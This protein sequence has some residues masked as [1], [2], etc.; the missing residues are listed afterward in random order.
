MHL[1][2]AS[3]ASLAVATGGGTFLYAADWPA[4]CS[5]A[6]ACGAMLARRMPRMLHVC[7]LLHWSCRCL[8]LRCASDK[9]SR[10][11]EEHMWPITEGHCALPGSHNVMHVRRMHRWQQ[12]SPSQRSRNPALRCPGEALGS[13]SEQR[14]RGLVAT[15]MASF[16][17]YS[18]D[19]VIQHYTSAGD[20]TDRTGRSSPGEPLQAA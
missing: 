5:A 19:C 14:V 9:A 20:G 18:T 3:A 7:Q 15:R 11:P 13:I 2:C 6:G 4:P 12:A 8:P 16:I 1:R 10:Q 17:P